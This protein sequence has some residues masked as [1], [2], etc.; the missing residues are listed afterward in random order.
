MNIK[1][2]FAASKVFHLL[3]IF[4]FLGSCTYIQTTDNR[5]LIYGLELTEG[6]A[7]ADCTSFKRMVRLNHTRPRLP[8]VDIGRLNQDEVTELLL[9]HTEKVKEY[10]DNEEKFLQEDIRR[11]NLKCSPQ[12]LNVFEK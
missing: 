8:K 10:L 4:A 12:D 11:Y 2:A 6:A 1:E 3:W 7:P 9:E 5:T